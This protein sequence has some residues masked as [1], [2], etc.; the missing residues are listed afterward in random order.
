MAGLGIIGQLIA[1]IADASAY[2]VYSYD[3]SRERTELLGSKQ[4]IKL[5]TERDDLEQAIGIDVIYRGVDAVFL[6]AAEKAAVNR[7]KFVMDR[8]KGKVVIV[9][10][11]EPDFPRGKMFSKEASILISRAGGPGRYDEVYEKQAID[12]HYG[13]VRW[14]EGR[15]MGEFLRMVSENRIDVSRYLTEEVAFDNISTAY[16]ELTNKDSAILTKVIKY[17]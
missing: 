16:E 6:C 13:F 8:D 12:Y 15:N 9:G 14:T 2:E 1:Q 3:L 11:I 17:D 5:F 7:T 4:N 10:D